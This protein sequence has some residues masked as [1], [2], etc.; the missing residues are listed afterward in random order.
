VSKT[1]ATFEAALATA[2]QCLKISAE[3]DATLTLAI[4]ATDAPKLLAAFDKLQDKSFVV[5]LVDVA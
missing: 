4:P 1:I 3:G 2:G 5:A